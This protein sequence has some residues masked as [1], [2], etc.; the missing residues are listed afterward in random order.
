[1][2]PSTTILMIGGR[3][4][5]PQLATRFSSP[6]YRF[7]YTTSLAEG[8]NEAPE[9]DLL[10]VSTGL[11]GHEVL[12]QRLRSDE[13]TAQIPTVLVVEPGRPSENLKAEA[14]VPASDFEALLRV[15]AELRPPE[16]LPEQPAPAEE[17]STEVAH[18]EFSGASDW[19]P[20]PPTKKPGQDL[21]TFAAV[22]AS[23]VDSL[24]AA[25][26]SEAPTSPAV[27]ARIDQVLRAVLEDIE[28]QQ[29]VIQGAITRA[30]V[31]GD[32]TV[33]HSLTS[34]KNGLYEKQKA[35]QGAVDSSAPAPPQRSTAAA[36]PTA[37]AATSAAAAAPVLPRATFEAPLPPPKKSELTLAAEAKIAAERAARIQQGKSAPME[38]AGAAEGQVRVPKPRRA[39]PRR[40]SASERRGG[41]GLLLALLVLGVLAAG[42]YFYA[43]RR[44][45]EPVAAQNRANTAPTM[46]WIAIEENPTGVILE[47]QATDPEDDRV[48][49]SVKWFLN[50]NPVEGAT[51]ARLPSEKY[52]RGDRVQAEVTPNDSYSRGAPMRS[53]ELTATK[54]AAHTLAPPAPPSPPPAPP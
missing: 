35:L 19:P 14:R 9:A 8:F 43:F 27:V 3:D 32:L 18:L 44:R 53:K 45:P 24:L 12:C 47:P 22:Y 1:V 7:L 52:S 51:T 20:S 2:P 41:L 28:N 50:G 37:A 25:I 48:S 4:L 6:P 34:A 11:P 16:P 40:E 29:R 54:P 49:Y 5:R 10:V 33:A 15:F 26:S 30:L 42:V 36:T 46:K 23:Y 17:E 39:A 21:L 31:G 13:L 38:T